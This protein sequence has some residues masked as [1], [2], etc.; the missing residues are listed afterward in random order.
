MFNSSAVLAVDVPVIE[1]I[2]GFFLHS[3]MYELILSIISSLS[4]IANLRN[5][6]LG[7]NAFGFID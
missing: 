1:Y 4:S 5:N 2:S 3:S 6:Q 7:I